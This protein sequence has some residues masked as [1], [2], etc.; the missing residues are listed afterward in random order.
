MCWEYTKLTIVINNS[1][2][3]VFVGKTLWHKKYHES[4]V[5]PANHLANI[6]TNKTKWHR[7]KQLGT[8]Q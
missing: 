1:S 3:Q 2:N 4:I 6:L 7:K 5:F 8:K